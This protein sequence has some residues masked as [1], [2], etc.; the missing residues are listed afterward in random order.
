VPNTFEEEV[1]LAGTRSSDDQESGSIVL[2]DGP[3]VVIPV[4][5]T[6]SVGQAREQGLDDVDLSSK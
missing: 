6:V 2:G 3:R 1:A 4:S 5:L